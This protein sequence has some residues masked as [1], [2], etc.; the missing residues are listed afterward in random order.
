MY[1]VHL[2][3]LWCITWIIF[4]TLSELDNIQICSQK[5]EEAQGKPM[6]D[7]TTL[8][9]KQGEQKAKQKWKYPSIPKVEPTDD[10]ICKTKIL[11]SNKCMP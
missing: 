1:S 5:G 8:K 11:L 3:I 10:S 4:L 9:P 7:Y 2:Y 6:V